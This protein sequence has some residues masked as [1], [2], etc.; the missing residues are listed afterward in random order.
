M[1]GSDVVRN[2]PLAP[3][4][5]EDEGP[6]GMGPMVGGVYSTNS[7]GMARDSALARIRAAISLSDLALWRSARLGL[8]RRRRRRMDL[9]LVVTE[10]LDEDEEEE[11]EDV[12]R[13][14]VDAHARAQ[15]DIA[16]STM[17]EIAPSRPANP[18]LLLE[19]DDPEL[20]D[21]EGGR[22]VLRAGV[23]GG[24]P[25][26]ISPPSS[27]STSLSDDLWSMTGS[28][29]KLRVCCRRGGIAVA[30]AWKWRVREC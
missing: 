30:M 18:E 11:D 26:K 1:R 10:L 25:R 21:T 20:D 22:G 24:S 6:T 13:E 15:W 12:D 17:V 19:D 27:L 7:L 16:C 3:G 4:S 2:T 23:W 29:R 8:G 9:D 5:E 14:D 28:S